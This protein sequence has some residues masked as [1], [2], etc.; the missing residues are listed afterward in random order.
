MFILGRTDL[1]KSLF[2]T[3]EFAYSEIKLPF[4]EIR[5]SCLC[6]EEFILL[7]GSYPRRLWA[8][9]L[10]YRCFKLIETFLQT[11]WNSFLCAFRSSFSA[12]H[13]SPYFIWSLRLSPSPFARDPLNFPPFN[14]YFCQT[15]LSFLSASNYTPFLNVYCAL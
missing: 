5:F 14:I 10:N 3:T 11:V 13:W 7:S 9:F 6:F 8:A 2:P 4:P 1:R 15:V 12:Y